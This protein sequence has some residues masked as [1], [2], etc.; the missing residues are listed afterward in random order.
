M[1]V[2][3]LHSQVEVVEVEAEEMHSREEMKEVE[4]LQP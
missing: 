2:A 4:T 3:E 1:E